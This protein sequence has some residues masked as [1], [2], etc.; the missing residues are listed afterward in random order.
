MSTPNPLS[1]HS[2]VYYASWFYIK[3]IPCL[4]KFIIFTSVMVKSILVHHWCW[5]TR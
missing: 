2:L 4:L 1:R 3:T 5:K